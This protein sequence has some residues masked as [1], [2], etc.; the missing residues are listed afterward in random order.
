MVS[1]TQIDE[2]YLHIEFSN[3]DHIKLQNGTTDKK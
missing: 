2:E 1:T 3:V